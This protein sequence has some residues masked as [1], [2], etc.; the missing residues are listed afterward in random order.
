M[1][2]P[3]YQKGY[4]FE[5]G[6]VEP[7]LKQLGGILTRAPQSGAF[8]GESDFRLVLPDFSTFTFSCKK[9]KENPS[10]FISNQCEEADFAIWA[11]DR[12]IP[13]IAGPFIK[14]NDFYRRVYA[15]EVE[16]MEVIE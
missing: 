3:S 1:P 11:W 15:A 2:N 6:V 13:Y 12:S 16:I 10:K 14:V 4:R 8:T 5:H 7:L 9:R